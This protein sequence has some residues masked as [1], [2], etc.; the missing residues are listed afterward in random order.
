VIEAHKQRAGKY[1]ILFARIVLYCALYLVNNS[2]LSCIQ[3]H[4]VLK[5]WRDKK[6]QLSNRQLQISKLRRY[7]CSEFQFLPPKFPENCVFLAPDFESLGER[8]KQEKK[9][10]AD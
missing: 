8:P 2:T 10:A 3:R 7:G 9:L 5:M 4:H 1:Q 6:L